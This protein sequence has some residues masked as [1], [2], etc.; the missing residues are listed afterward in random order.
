MSVIFL[1][2]CTSAGKS[3]LARELQDQLQTPYLLTGIDDAFARMPAH[4]HNHPDG[5]FFDRDERGLVRLNFGAFGMATMRAH[6]QAAAAMARSGCNLILDEVLLTH[7]LRQHWWQSLKGLDVALVGVRCALAELERRET[8]RGDRMRGQARGQYDLV[9]DGMIY[10]IEV[11]S[12]QTHAAELAA[13][14][15]KAL[16][17]AGVGTAFEQMRGD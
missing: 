7:E 3:S 10:D 1:N 16:Q 6:H 12:T 2:G 9:H 17:E 4:L 11:D 15:I 14:I 13:M 5:V 8:A